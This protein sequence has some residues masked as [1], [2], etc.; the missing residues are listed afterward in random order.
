MTPWTVA[1]QAPLS[2]EIFRQEYWSGF[3]FP[4]PG[5]LPDPGI[6]PGSPHRR[7]FTIWATISSVQF[8]HSVVSD[9]L[10]PH[11]LQP[12][13]L[14]SPWDSPGKNIGVGFHFLLQGIFLTQGLNPSLLD[15]RQTLYQ[16][17]YKV[18]P[19][20]SRHKIKTCYYHEKYFTA[21]LCFTYNEKHFI[22]NKWKS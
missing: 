14:L 9:S 5:D 4:S 13:R 12:V 18:S 15:C 6:E 1:H 20:S 19:G 22:E 21:F 10:Q 17:S 7:C 3:P 16:L 11:G 2:M 8:S